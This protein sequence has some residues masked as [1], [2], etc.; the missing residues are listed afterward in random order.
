MEVSERY[1][2]DWRVGSIP[3]SGPIL[4]RFPTQAH[5]S[6]S[7]G[8]KKYRRGGSRKMSRSDKEQNK[9]LNECVLNWLE[10]LASH[11]GTTQDEEQINIFIHALKDNTTYQVETAFER[12]LNE[13]QFM[14]RLREVHERMPAT[15]WPPENPGNFLKRKPTLELIRPIA[16]EICKELTGREYH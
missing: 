5:G 13:C 4:R 6:T 1:W 8:G 15:R 2:P 3:N 14:P 7:S 10:K 9:Q 11:F 16:L 12:C